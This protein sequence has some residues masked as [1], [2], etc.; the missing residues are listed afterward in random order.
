MFAL[1]ANAHLKLGNP[2]LA[3]RAASTGLLVHKTDP[4]LLDLLLTAQSLQGQV[5]NAVATA[6]QRLALR[7]DAGTLL[8]A[9]AHLLRLAVSVPESRL[10]EAF[11]NVHEA[12]AL[13][14]E[15][16][17]AAPQDARVRVVRARALIALE[18]WQDAK[19]ELA[20]FP[21]AAGVARPDRASG[22]VC[23]ACAAASNTWLARG[24]GL[25]A[26]RVWRGKSWLTSANA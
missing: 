12:L 7:R 23:A 17:T 24:A 10:P 8:D 13:A 16:R 1:L 11:A 21:G 20:D 25:L 19:A 2:G 9:A 26:A 5:S 15:A 4:A 18:R 6:R 3:E 14:S 22:D